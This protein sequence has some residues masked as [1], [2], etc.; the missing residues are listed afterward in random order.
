MP[1]R[2]RILPLAALLAGVALLASACSLTHLP[3]PDGEDRP[4]STRAPG[5][6]ASPDRPGP[7]APPCGW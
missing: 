2:R 3:A 7:P 4:P 5:R 6:P 1:H